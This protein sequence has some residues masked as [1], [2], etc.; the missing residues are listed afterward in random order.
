MQVTDQPMA[1]DRNA[2]AQLQGWYYVIT[3]GWPMLSMGTFELIA[4]PKRERW[5]VRSVALLLCVI[6]GSLEQAARYERIT[7]ETRIVG[8]GTAASLAAIDVL[9]VVR[10]TLRPVY[11]LDAL[12]ELLFIRGWWRA[13]PAA[14]ARSTRRGVG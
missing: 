4:G 5:L 14:D 13:S 3:G 7:P 6:G 1:R 8:V 12:V 2:V 10:G 11:L 9:Y